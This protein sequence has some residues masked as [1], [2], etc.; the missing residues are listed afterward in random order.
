MDNPDCGTVAIQFDDIES[1]QAIGKAE[2]KYFFLSFTH[3]V[4]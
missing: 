1:V 3:S 2:S 4:V